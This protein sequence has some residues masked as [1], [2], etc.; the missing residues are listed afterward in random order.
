MFGTF[1]MPENE[2]PDTYGIDDESFPSSFGAQLL[3]PFLQ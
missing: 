1:Y 3:H 2:L